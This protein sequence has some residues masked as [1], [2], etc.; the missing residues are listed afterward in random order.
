MVGGESFN[1]LTA[2]GNLCEEGLL[3]SPF[4]RLPL[5]GT[6]S[7]TSWFQGSVSSQSFVGGCF[8]R[9]GGTGFSEV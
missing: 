6:H 7:L 1:I 4:K 2:S 5:S 8:T 9:Q 3:L